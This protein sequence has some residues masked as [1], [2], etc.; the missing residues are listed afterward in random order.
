[1]RMRMI[2]TH[3]TTLCVIVDSLTGSLGGN[4]AWG[5]VELHIMVE[6]SHPKGKLRGQIRC[7]NSLKR[8]SPSKMQSL[9]N[10][11]PKLCI[12]A[13]SYNDQSPLSLTLSPGLFL[14]PC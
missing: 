12:S 3:V 4:L 6:N 11:Q 13:Q 1:M 5:S 2:T 7:L 9:A 10:F 14:F 8:V